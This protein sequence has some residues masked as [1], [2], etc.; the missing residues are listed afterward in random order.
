VRILEELHK[1]GVETYVIVS[2]AAEITLKAE[3]ECDFS[4]LKSISTKFYSSDDIAAPMSSGSFKHDGMTIAPCSMKTAASIAYNL[5]DNLITRAADVTLKEGRKLVLLVRETPL[6]SGHLRVLLQ[7]SELG[8]IVM[9]P[10]PAFYTKP[11]SIDD[12]VN[13]TVARV[14]EKFGID[15][16]CKR[17]EGIE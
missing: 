1:K 14:L 2:K 5:T 3:T 6:H 11:K 8:A 13:H 9:P 17:W 12:L 7:L 10:L 4:Y 16:N 15:V